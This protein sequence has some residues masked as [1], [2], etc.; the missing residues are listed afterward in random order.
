MRFQVSVTTNYKNEKK[1]IG[2]EINVWN[3]ER[4]E[5]REFIIRGG[6]LTW[7]FRR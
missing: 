5:G 2:W 6:S 1:N 3:S 4:K 7:R